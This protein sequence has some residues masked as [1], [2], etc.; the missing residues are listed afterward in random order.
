[1]ICR[2][3]LGSI[4]AYDKTDKISASGR[5][6]RIQRFVYIFLRILPVE[7]LETSAIAVALACE[8]SLESLAA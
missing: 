4:F 3:L 6:Q 2:L 8:G 5:I 7:G 1:L